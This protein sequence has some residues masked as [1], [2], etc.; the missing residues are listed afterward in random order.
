MDYKDLPA[1]EVFHWF[2]EINQIPRGSE[3]EKEFLISYTI[4]LRKEI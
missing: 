2:R 1:Q 3:D 4:G